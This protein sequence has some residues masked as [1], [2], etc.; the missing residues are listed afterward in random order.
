MK[1]FPVLVNAAD[2]A[3]VL[4]NTRRALAWEHGDNIPLVGDCLE[5]TVVGKPGACHRVVTDS[6]PEGAVAVV[7]LRPLIKAE[8]EALK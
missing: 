8:K 7:S 6:S 3:A 5:L 1:I 4:A 2:F